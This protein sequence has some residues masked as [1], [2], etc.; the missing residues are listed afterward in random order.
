MTNNLERRLSE[1]VGGYSSFARKYNIRKL[2][3][4]EIHKKALEAIARE[5]QI[6]KWSRKKKI[7]LIELIN[8]AWGDL[9]RLPKKTTSIMTTKPFTWSYLP[10]NIHHHHGNQA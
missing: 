5:N 9:S 7:F 3:Y 1:H 2:V 4:Y 6:K 8:P 10:P